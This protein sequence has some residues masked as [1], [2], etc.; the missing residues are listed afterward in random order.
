MDQVFF[1]NLLTFGFI[2]IAHGD[3]KLF[4]KTATLQYDANT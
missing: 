3:N 1:K 4:K 2:H